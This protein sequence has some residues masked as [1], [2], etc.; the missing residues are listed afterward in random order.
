MSVY[1]L[2]PHEIKI[3]S[4]DNKHSV[5]ATYPPH[6]NALRGIHNLGDMCGVLTPDDVPIYMIGRYE[7]DVNEWNKMQLKCNDIILMSTIGAEQ[8]ETLAKESGVSVLIPASG[9]NQCAR[10]EKG[11][12]LGSYFFKTILK[13]EYTSICYNLFWCLDWNGCHNMFPWNK[14]IWNKCFINVG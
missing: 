4:N 8:Y 3:L 1:N 13:D 2:T 11:E 12:I 10:N 6:K 5:I 14:E 7:P 9:P